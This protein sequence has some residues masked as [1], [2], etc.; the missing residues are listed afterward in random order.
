MRRGPRGEERCVYELHQVGE[1][2]YYVDGPTQVGIVEVGQG[3]VCLIDTGNDKTAGKRLLRILNA[4]GWHL[5]GVFVTHAH[6][7]HIGGVRYLQNQTGCPAYAR[8][9]ERAFA[10][11]TELEGAL[12]Y[13]GYA[14]HQLRHKFLRAQ[15]AE[16]SELGCEVLPPNMEMLELPGHSPHMVG[17]RTAD[18]V[19]FLADCLAS[20][21]T[22]ATYRIA[23]LYD[24]ATYLK[25][26]EEVRLMKADLF[27]PAHAPATTS[28]ASLVE[29]NVQ[30][31]YG[32]AD[33]LEALCARPLTSE[34]LLRAVF[35]RYQLPMSFEQ[36]ALVGFTMRS[37]LAWL[38]D[39]GRVSARIEDNRW[40]WQ[41]V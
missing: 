25:T 20:E 35:E 32:V 23:F 4:H 7:D 18:N 41:R 40:L 14:P 5:S 28:I 2:T 29:A 3:E 33:D 34:E 15:E 39:Q 11:V 24:V 9:V 22:I 12:L 38:Q 1:H 16:V 21:R 30:S 27:V 36:H 37:Y 13:G 19:V 17:F 26:L 8:G 31:V 6:A 10:Q